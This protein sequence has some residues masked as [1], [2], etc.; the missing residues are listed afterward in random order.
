MAV[1]RAHF[2]HDDAI[3]GVPT[4]DLA[5]RLVVLREPDGRNPRQPSSRWV[6]GT[7]LARHPL[8]NPLEARQD[9]GVVVGL[10]IQSVRHWSCLKKPSSG[11]SGEHL[12]A[13][14]SEF[15]RFGRSTGRCE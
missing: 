3:A 14:P 8:L 5:L 7:T 6:H 4:M 10:S 13:V 1:R 12:S 15:V 11:T 9:P 2:A